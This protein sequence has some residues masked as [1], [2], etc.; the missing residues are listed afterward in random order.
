MKLISTSTVQPVPKPKLAV[1]AVQNTKP[2]IWIDSLGKPPVPDEKTVVELNKLAS[3]RPFSSLH[4]AK[5]R[6][7]L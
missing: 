2:C 6:D 3:R 1:A 5:D 4:K 7:C